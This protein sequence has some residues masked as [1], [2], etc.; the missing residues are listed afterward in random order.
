MFSEK[1]LIITFS[2]S[3]ESLTKETSLNFLNGERFNIFGSINTITFSP[4]E[5]A[6]TDAEVVEPQKTIVLRGSKSEIGS[7]VILIFRELK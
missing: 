6:S 1:N 2:N 4:Y 3:S 5:N 7:S